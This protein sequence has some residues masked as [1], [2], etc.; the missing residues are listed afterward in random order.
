V[1]SSATLASLWSRRGK[2]S[3]R[4]VADGYPCPSSSSSK[5]QLL[6][7]RADRCSPDRAPIRRW[8]FLKFMKRVALG[9]AAMAILATL[10][11]PISAADP[12][13]HLKS[14]IDAA[15]SESG[16]GPL[17]LDPI[18]NAIS[19]R[20]AHEADDYVRHAATTLP[21]TGEIDLRPTGTGGVLR[22]MRE[23]GD[24][25]NSARLLNGYGDYRT[26]GTGDN[27]DKAIKAAVLQG[28]G[29]EALSNCTAYTKYG[30]SAINDSGQEGWPSTEPRP[31]SVAAVVLA[32]A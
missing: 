18:L 14:E 4:L 16:C 17:Q 1:S 30:L 21:T 25:T 15:R 24:N 13:A 12:T 7:Q 29:S 31:F 8:E 32:G 19:Q 22:V 23:Y 20:V 9:T 27:E 11:A 10:F 6:E 2:V 28:L 3:Q 26:G 5:C